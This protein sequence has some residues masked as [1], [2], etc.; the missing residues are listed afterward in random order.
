MMLSAASGFLARPMKR[1]LA[2]A[3]VAACMACAADGRRAPAA[4]ASDSSG[5]G[6]ARSAATGSPLPEPRPEADAAYLVWSADS[7]WKKVET[8]WIDGAGEVVARRVGAVVAA[9]GG[10]WAWTER[11]RPFVATNCDC[12]RKHDYD[13]NAH[14]PEP[15]RVT[16]V[17][18]VDLLGTRRVTVL[19]ERHDVSVAAPRQSAS[20]YAGVGPYLFAET[21]TESYDCYN[22]TGVA[23]EPKVLDLSRGGA[24]AGLVDSA[25]AAAIKARQGIEAREVM[26]RDGSE[27]FEAAETE[28]GTPDFSS[29]EA[30]WTPEGRL[31]VSYRFLTG[32]C[33]LCY[34]EHAGSYSRSA[35]VLAADMPPKLAPYAVAPDAVR[36]YWRRSPPDV[37]AGWSR[38]D[39]ADP[40][41]ALARFRG[42]R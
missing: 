23:V 26:R 41:A 22:H 32:A 13:P 6:S 20:L 14:C 31:R 24:D 3:L 19:G 21:Y 28:P 25:G 5:P 11:E 37:Y 39:A 35:A 34:N 17:E 29:V 8:A 10:L 15:A 16:V 9:S 4:S 30:A 36:L 7:A 12:Y 40:A 2:I 42:G 33:A 38:V 27:P 18:L 1:F